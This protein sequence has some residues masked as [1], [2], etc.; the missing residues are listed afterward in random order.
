MRSLD[1]LIDGGA[2]F[3]G[4]RWHD[5]RLWVSDFWRHHVLAVAPDGSAETVAE[6]PGSPSGIGWLPDGTPLI[7]SMMDNTLLKLVD[8]E[9]VPFADL[10]EAAA[11]GAANDMVVDAAGRAYIGCCDV[12]NWDARPATN[13]V[14]VDPDGSVTVVA[15]GMSFPNGPAITPDGATL[16]IA[17][18][19]AERL[20]AFDIGPGGALDGRRVWAHVPGSPP[21]GIALDAEGAVW[22]ADAGGNRAVRVREGGEILD[23]VSAGDLGV[24]ACALGGEDGRTLFLCAAP[25]YDPEQ[26]AR[27]RQGRVLTCRVPVPHAGRG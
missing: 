2:F 9:P 15:E 3:E 20:T 6:V 4:P 18:S 8:G 13:L 25:T 11:G 21:D 23:E 27:I 19:W 16:I 1:T 24:F 7:V 17:E 10:S 5:G 14:R 12:M 26:A 22:M